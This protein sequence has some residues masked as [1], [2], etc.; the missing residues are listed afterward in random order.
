MSPERTTAAVNSHVAPTSAFATSPNLDLSSGQMEAAISGASGESA[1]FIAATRLAYALLGDAIAANLFLLGYAY[2]LG[3]LPVGLG[4]LERAIELNG[5]AVEMNKRAVAWGRL[6]VHDLERV[7]E[8]A[9]PGHRASEQPPAAETLDALVK[10]CAE[11]LSEY[12]SSAYARRYVDLVERV[13]AREGAELAAGTRLAEAVA[14]YYFK[15]L[16]YKDE[17]EVA[18]LWTN[19][20]F[21]RQLNAEFEGDFKIQL[22]L[23]PQ[24]LFPKDPDTGRAKKLTVGPWVLRAFKLLARFKFLRGSPFDPFGWV[25]HRRLERQLIRDYEVRTEEL[26]AGLSS[27]NLDLAVEIASLPEGIRGFFDVKG[28]PSRGRAH[29]GG[30]SCWQPSQGAR[31]E[32]ARPAMAARGGD[33]VHGLRLRE[34]RERSSP[35]GRAGRDR[36]AS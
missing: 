30:R 26:L 8:A 10:R 14:R 27:E 9:R 18:R 36:Y 33:G 13:S 32:R 15:L 5:R 22:H 28:A 29:E 7:E 24:I 20:D 23:A 17:Y 2:Q 19:G 35:L 4:A 31:R 12:Q 6:A 16:A 1:H 11:F 21:L 25:P 3:R 34:S